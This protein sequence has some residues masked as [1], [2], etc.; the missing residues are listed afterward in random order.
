MCKRTR[1][2]TNSRNAC[3]MEKFLL[4]LA[5]L[6]IFQPAVCDVRYNT[7]HSD[8]FAIGSAN[9]PP[10]VT[11]PTCKTAFMTNPIF[12]FVRVCFSDGLIKRFFGS[13]PVFRMHSFQDCVL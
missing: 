1:K 8:K 11:D 7:H 9:T 13:I 10:P 12:H 5:R 2:L 6:Q 3:K 4:P